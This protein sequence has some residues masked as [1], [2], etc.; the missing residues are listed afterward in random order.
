MKLF[1]PSYY[2]NFKCIADKCKNSCCIGWEIDIDAATLEKYKNLKSGYGI[3]IMETISM[4]DTPHFKLCKGERCPHLDENG[5]CKIIINEGESYL[6]DICREHP[7]FYNYTSVCEMGIGMSCEE[8][9]RV[10]L[11]S[12][13]Y[14]K[15]EYIGEVD[16]EEF[17]TDFDGTVERSEIYKILHSAKDYKTALEEIYSKYQ[18]GIGEDKVYL[19]TLD[20]LEYLDEKHRE[21]FGNYSSKN[22]LDIGCDKYLERFLAYL[23]YRHTTEAFDYDDFVLRLSFCLFCERLLASL[24]CFKKAEELNDV[25]TLARIISEEIEYSEDNTEA[26]MY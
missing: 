10:I 8:A 16:I 1:A 11:S 12:P 2:K 19:K 5:L 13:D 23:I 14:D 15:L 24:M 4:E 21:L 20:S 25:A 17:R 7:R 26:L 22:R 3:S 18:I 6:S 9:A